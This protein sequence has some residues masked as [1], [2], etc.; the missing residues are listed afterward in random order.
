MEHRTGF[1]PVSGALATPCLG[2]S[3][4]TIRRRCEW[5][6]RTELNCSPQVPR[7]RMF[8][9]HHTPKRRNKEGSRNAKLKQL[10][11]L[12]SQKLSLGCA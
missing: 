1:E 7:T 8:A 5:S 4:L 6:G 2:P 3:G 11:M 9:L 12:A 10:V